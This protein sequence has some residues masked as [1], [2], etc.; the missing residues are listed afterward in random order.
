[1]AMWQR[2]P[3]RAAAMLAHPEIASGK[4]DL[5]MRFLQIAAGVRKIEP[6]QLWEGVVIGVQT[7]SP[8][9]RLFFHQMSTEIHAF[10]GETDSAMRSL[11]RAVD[12]GLCDLIWY[13][14]CPL[15]DVL[16]RDLRFKALRKV[17]AGRS[18]Q[19]KAALRE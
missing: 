2:T 8:R 4:Q 15:L 10:Q 7:S 11:A 13:D 16:R 12:V 6:A 18:A 14:R 19:V 17:I 3:D 9:G 5:V 1:M